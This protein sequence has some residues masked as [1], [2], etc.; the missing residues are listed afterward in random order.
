[1][2]NEIEKTKR[3]P[4]AIN[5]EGGDRSRYSFSIRTPALSIIT[6]TPETE[7]KAMMA[8]PEKYGLVSEEV[9]MKLVAHLARVC[10]EVNVGLKHSSTFKER[11]KEEDVN[12][13]HLSFFDEEDLNSYYL[14]EPSLLYNGQRCWFV[15]FKLMANWD[16]VLMLLEEALKNFMKSQMT[17]HELK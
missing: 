5:D 13:K 3:V 12:E 4:F 7:I 14:S 2:S 8:T 9:F 17:Q 1:M 15:F 10:R 6:S 16:S 11:C